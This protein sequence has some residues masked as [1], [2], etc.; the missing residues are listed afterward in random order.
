MI[1]KLYGI[2]FGFILILFGATLQ[3]VE[4][5][6]P[7]FTPLPPPE[8]PKEEVRR[9]IPAE[10]QR[11]AWCE[12]NNRHFDENGEVIKGAINPLDTG[13]YQINLFYHQTQAEALGFDL[14]TE[15]GNEAYALWLYDN[16]NGAWHWR[17][18]ES[19]WS[20]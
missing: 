5:P 2:Y 4:A 13:R 3:V 19:C 8:P 17:W 15:D 14:F 16:G 6:V 12:S 9:V 10:L 1:K 7:L 20:E 18:S 11:I